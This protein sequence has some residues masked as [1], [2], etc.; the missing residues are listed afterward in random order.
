QLL[1]PASPLVQ[2]VRPVELLQILRNRYERKQHVVQFIGIAH[3]RP[4]VLPHLRDSGWV[5]M[6][7]LIEHCNGKYAAH[8]DS[9]SPALL[10][11]SVVKISIG[12][13]IKNLVRE[14]R[15]N[16]S[17]DSNALDSAAFDL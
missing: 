4:G 17:I 7:N 15:R 1:K 8:L 13:G 16:G 10:E 6:A 9:S 5:E 3:I 11:R 12:M 14:D 2:R